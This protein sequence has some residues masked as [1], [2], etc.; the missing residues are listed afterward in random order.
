MQIDIILIIFTHYIIISILEGILII[1]MT[2]TI[3]QFLTRFSKLTC[4]IFKAN[5]LIFF[6]NNR[7]DVFC[8]V[9]V[10]NSS[11]VD[12]RDGIVRAIFERTYTPFLMKTPVRV[13]V[14]VIFVAALATHVTIFPQMEIGLDQKLS[15]SED[16]Y[17]LKYFTVKSKKQYKK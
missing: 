5:N 3:F 13:V 4:A 6:Q 12:E 8:C 11:N 16:S 15:M 17:V 2:I 9:S 10:K 7:L 1:L 14:I